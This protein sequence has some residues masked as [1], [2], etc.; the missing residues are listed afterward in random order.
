MNYWTTKSGQKIKVNDMKLRHVD[1]TLK[2]LITNY[3]QWCRFHGG[4]NRCSIDLSKMCENEKRTMLDKTCED[5][6]FLKQIVA[7]ECFDDT[8]IDFY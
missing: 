1:N 4:R 3:R 5:R 2:M 7:R 8:Y 6:S